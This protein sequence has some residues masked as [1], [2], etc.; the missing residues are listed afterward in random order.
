MEG[1]GLA[2]SFLENVSY[3][4]DQIG[5]NPN[6]VLLIYSDGITEAMNQKEE[7]YGEQRLQALVNGIKGETAQEIINRVLDSVNTYVEDRQ[8]MD[9]MTLVV[10]KR[11]K[12]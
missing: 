7:E 8:Q 6:D 12:D 5:F 3:P 2:L 11:K 4:E 9:D 10:I 1:A